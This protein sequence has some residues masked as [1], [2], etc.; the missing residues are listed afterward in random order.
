MDPDLEGGGRGRGVANKLKMVDSSSRN[1]FDLPHAR[2]LFYNLNCYPTIAINMKSYEIPLI[3]GVRDG[4]E[5]N[6]HDMIFFCFLDY[7]SHN[8]SK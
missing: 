5:F 6:S 1:L 8:E 2:C 3:K 7:L 4:D